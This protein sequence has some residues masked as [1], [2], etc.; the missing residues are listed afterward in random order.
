MSS[1][2]PYVQGSRT[3]LEADPLAAVVDAVLAHPRALE[4]VH[5]VVRAELQRAPVAEP[6]WCSKA[7]AHRRGFPAASTLRSWQAAG[8]ITTGRRGRVNLEELRRVLAARGEEPR[9]VA[10]LHD[11]RVKRTAAALVKPNR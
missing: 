4:L 5:Q 1:E 6:T 7:E 11:E 8:V 2:T 3:P 10:N 9:P